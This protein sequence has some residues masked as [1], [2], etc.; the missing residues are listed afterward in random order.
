M[1]AKILTRSVV[2]LLIASCVMVHMQSTTQVSP[3][4]RRTT[5]KQGFIKT[6]FQGM[7]YL[8]GPV[9]MVYDGI[10]FS[11]SFFTIIDE[12][13]ADTQNT[14]NKI[15]KMLNDNFLPE[16]AASTTPSSTTESSDPNVTTKKP[17]YRITRS[18]FMKILNRNVKGLRRLF[19]IELKEA[20][21]QSRITDKEFRKT[22]Q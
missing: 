4:A 3:K 12:Q 10:S 17:P 9:R 16:N 18:E 21:Q 15:S 11:N 6:L 19:D 5:P 20:L 2:V 22:Y 7:N 14:L 13:W 8:V 1:C